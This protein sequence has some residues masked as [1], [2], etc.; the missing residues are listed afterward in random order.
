MLHFPFED[1]ASPCK[2]EAWLDPSVCDITLSHK[3][4]DLAFLLEDVFMLH[5]HGAV[6]TVHTEE[7]LQVLDQ[8]CR[9]VARRVKPFL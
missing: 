5:S 8:A 3:V 7:D 2:P 6:S 9:K 4:L 1:D